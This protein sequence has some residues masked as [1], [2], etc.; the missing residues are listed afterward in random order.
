MAS[1]TI[2]DQFGVSLLTASSGPGSGIS[3]YFSGQTAAFLASAELAQ[4]L[5]KPVSSLTPDPL[6]LGLNFAADGE[7][8]TASV[9]WKLAAGARVAVYATQA[10]QELPGDAVFSHPVK[11]LP[12]KTIV[13]TSFAPSLSVGLSEGIGDLQF[14][15]SVGGTVDFRAGREFDLGGGAG[16]TLGDALRSLLSTAVV[17]ANVLDLAEMAEGDI[18]SLSG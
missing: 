10:G 11:V 8:G 4:A 12:G 15:F 14:G 18:G 13:A 3:K 5:T 1:I 2:D 17:P 9:D 16:P 6:G 7:F